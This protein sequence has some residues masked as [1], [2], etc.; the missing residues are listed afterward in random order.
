MIFAKESTQPT[1]PDS[2]HRCSATMVDLKM[3]ESS[4]GGVKLQYLRAG[5]R[6][7]FLATICSNS[8]GIGRLRSSIIV[9]SAVLEV[10]SNEIND[11]RI[12]ELEAMGLPIGS[13]ESDVEWPITTQGQLKGM[14]VRNF[15]S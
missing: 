9:E 12:R 10:E 5:F 15:K 14:T 11:K 7:Q 13:W 8:G 6:M 1:F 2:L 4:A 3:S